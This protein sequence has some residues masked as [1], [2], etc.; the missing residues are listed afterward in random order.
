MHACMAKNQKNR[1]MKAE[2]RSSEKLNTSIEWTES[3]ERIRRL[4]VYDRIEKLSGG[5]RPT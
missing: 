3:D 2:E 5:T 4:T 1:L